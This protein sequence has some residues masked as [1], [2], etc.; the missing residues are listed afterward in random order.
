MNTKETQ[1]PVV[2][3]SEVI[4]SNH[5][6]PG[7]FRYI[8]RFIFIFIYVYLC[9]WTQCQLQ[10]NT[11][12][13][14]KKISEPLGSH[15]LWVLRTKLCSSGKAEGTHDHRTTLPVLVYFIIYL[16]FIRQLAQLEILNE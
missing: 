1:I 3:P 13:G 5:I 11:C 7:N 9:E 10:M 2:K 8:H 14:Q 6:V 16:F 15:P 12:R 4:V